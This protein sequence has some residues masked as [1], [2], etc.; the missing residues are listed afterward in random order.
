MTLE[1]F[2]ALFNRAFRYAY[3]RKKSYFLFTVLSCVG[4]LFLFFQGVSLSQEAWLQNSLLFI[5]LFF[6]MGAVLAAQVLLSKFYKKEIEGET[7]TFRRTLFE[8]G[9]AMLKISYL[10]IPLL[11]LYLLFW[12][13]SS[14]FLLLHTIPF[15]GPFLTVVLAFVPFMLNLL[16]VVLVL[17][18]LMISFFIAPQIALEGALDRRALVMRLRSDV[19][20]NLLFFLVPAAVV[21][22]TYKVL[23]IAVRLTLGGA[24]LEGASLE[25]MLQAFFIMLPFLAVM[26][27]VVNF[28][29]NFAVEGYIVLQEECASR[30]HLR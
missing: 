3:S 1:K 23:F 21:L 7:P 2:S 13:F 17:I 19:F 5:P 11:L 22:F 14:L 10:T 8:S 4:L 9:E 6:G 28:F 20:L 27:P 25:A 24:V 30:D 15:L 18:T 16:S 26:T 29:F 12:V